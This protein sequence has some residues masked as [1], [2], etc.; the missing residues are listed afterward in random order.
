[1]STRA[2]LVAAACSLASCG[3]H[4]G[5][6]ADLL[7]RRIHTIAIPAFGNATDN[8]KLSER[9]TS[10]VTREFIARSQYR[11]VADPAQADAVL[12]GAV[13]NLLSYSTVFDP[14]TNRASGAQVMV[15]MQVSLTDRSNGAVL[16]SRPNFEFRERYE[17]SVDAKTYFEESDAALERLSRDVARSVVS[18]VLEGF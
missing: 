7:P 9:V 14:T 18:A 12:N 16:F 3:Y 1:M 4:V 11:I 10:A 8:Y 17:I 13:I 6:K 2:L 15:I 5:G